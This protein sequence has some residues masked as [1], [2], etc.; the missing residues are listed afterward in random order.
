MQILQET[1]WYNMTQCIWRDVNNVTRNINALDL[2]PT[3]IVIN[4]YSQA[5]ISKIIGANYLLGPFG[6]AAET[7]NKIVIEQLRMEVMF[8][9]V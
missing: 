2:Y 8:T 3:I 9:A 6:V 5:H 1:D 4:S 7:P